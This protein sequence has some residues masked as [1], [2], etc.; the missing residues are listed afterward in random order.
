MIKHQHDK[1]SSY[2]H[3]EL[4]NLIPWYVKDKLTPN[5]RTAVEQHLA[6]CES[7]RQE[8]SDC[9]ALIDSL[10]KP[11]ESWQPS[12]AHFAGILASL[13]KLEANEELEKST[14]IVSKPGFFQ[15]IRQIFSQT[16]RQVRW[17]L[18]AETLAFA[19]LAAFLVLPGHISTNQ[20]GTYETLSTVESPAMIKGRSIRLVFAEDMTTRELSDLLRNAKAQIRQGPSEVGSFTVE[21]EFKEEKQSLSV[22]RS[23][24]KVLFAQPVE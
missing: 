11:Q 22:L 19:A 8:V 7:C 13:D 24:P 21:V 12:A 3:D 20:I 15:R 9:Q 1:V 17:T 10:P 23:N 2:H 5:E 4:V 6:D 16:P 14:Q 18:M